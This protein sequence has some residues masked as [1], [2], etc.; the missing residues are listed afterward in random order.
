MTSNRFIVRELVT[1]TPMLFPEDPAM[2]NVNT[3]CNKM[4]R[5]PLQG[6]RLV[7]DQGVEGRR[8]NEI[9]VGLNEIRQGK[10]SLA[11]NFK[12]Q[13]DSTVE[14]EGILKHALENAEGNQRKLQDP[15]PQQRVP[16]E[17][18]WLLKRPWKDTRK[19]YWPNMTKEV[20]DLCRNCSTCAS[21]NGNLRRK[22]YDIN[23]LEMWSD[24]VVFWNA[25]RKGRI[26][27][28]MMTVGLD[29]PIARVVSIFQGKRDKATRTFP[30]LLS[31]TGKPVWLKHALEIEK[32]K[33][34][35]VY[36]RKATSPGNRLRED[37]CMT[38]SETRQEP[39]MQ[40]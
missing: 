30:L 39:C 3:A 20:N 32:G 14:D 36:N 23:Y 40:R 16:G 37:L 34:Q 7:N 28:C 11:K 4:T 18:I 9:P 33:W 2:K 19:F 29:V 27:E 8:Q 21:A 24:N 6:V 10:T 13:W 35:E 12:T 15:V 26:Q 25:E 31:E 38:S 5:K 17:A 1:G 22:K